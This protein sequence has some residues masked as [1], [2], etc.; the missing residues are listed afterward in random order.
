MDLPSLFRRNHRAK[1][2]CRRENREGGFTLLETLLAI[3][4]G[5]LMLTTFGYAAQERANDIRD[6]AAAE[7]LK[8]LTQATDSWV[9]D[10]WNAVVSAA[11][12]AYPTTTIAAYLPTGFGN[13]PYGMKYSIVTRPIMHG[14]V[15]SGAEVLIAAGD[16]TFPVD[17]K[18]SPMI[19]AMAGATGAT[20]PTPVT[21]QGAYGGWSSSTAGF[22]ATGLGTPV[23]ASLLYQD[24]G[25]ILADYL[26]R[27]VVP[28]HPELNRMNADLDMGG[29]DI[30]NIKDANALGNINACT[31]TAAG[32]GAN[33]TGCGV[34]IANGRGGFY[35]DIN[36]WIYFRGTGSGLS[37]GDSTTPKNLSVSGDLA[38]NDIYLTKYSQWL[39]PLASWRG[40]A[41]W[42][43]D[44]SNN[45]VPKPTCPNSGTARIIV[46]PQQQSTVVTQDAVAIPQCGTYSYPFCK[47]AGGANRMH[48]IDNGGSWTVEMKYMDN[49]ALD[50][51]CDANGWCP[52]SI[53]ISI[54]LTYCHYPTGA[55]YSDSSATIP[56]APPY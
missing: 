4:I 35:N 50:P 49:N 16:P 39:T 18:R 15:L 36:G 3:G 19:A 23:V 48:A 9:R 43:V 8:I 20:F 54:A 53:A 13:N 10:N 21:I 51:A 31:D 34:T 1:A 30:D 2:P 38:V 56:T 7:H 11:P 41:G 22:A 44:A 28:G 40:M 24:N 37:I 5:A 33:L 45:V 26:Y 47:Y 52:D 12:A 46:V 27:N 42:Y 55:P 6:K 32:A 14:A 17:G 25:A 29:N